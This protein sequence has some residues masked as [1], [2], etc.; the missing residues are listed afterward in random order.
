MFFLQRLSGRDADMCTSVSKPEAGH[1]FPTLGSTT[2]EAVGGSTSELP[3]TRV[4][5]A[6]HEISPHLDGRPLGPV[7]LLI[8][9]L[10]HLPCLHILATT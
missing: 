2:P 1:A 4:L 7:G 9:V 10:P 5:Y 8:P 3:G 6:I